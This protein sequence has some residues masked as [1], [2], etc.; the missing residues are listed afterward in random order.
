MTSFDDEQRFDVAGGVGCSEFARIIGAAHPEVSRAASAGLLNVI[1]RKSGA[2]GREV[3][4]LD[5]DH[6]M[7]IAAAVECGIPWRVAAALGD[8]IIVIKSGG[9]RVR[10]AWLDGKTNRT[11]TDKKYRKGSFHRKH[12][13]KAAASN[14]TRG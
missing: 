11:V 12:A 14:A 8:R 13:R 2:N 1:G 9:I 4:I 5:R 7:R 3:V 6:A 10:S